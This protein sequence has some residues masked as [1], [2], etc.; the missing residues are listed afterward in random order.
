MPSA[1]L[2]LQTRWRKHSFSAKTR[3]VFNADRICSQQDGC[4]QK[5]LAVLYSK[6]GRT[7]N[8]LERPSLLTWWFPEWKYMYHA[9]LG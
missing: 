3:K 5:A 6:T 7:E 4:A 8:P 9:L 1:I 2:Q